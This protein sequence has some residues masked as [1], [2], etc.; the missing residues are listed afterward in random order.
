M[1][2]ISSRET[3]SV[4][5]ASDGLP[6]EVWR[7]P[8]ERS[9]FRVELKKTAPDRSGEPVVTV[10]L[11]QVRPKTRTVSTRRSACASQLWR[12]R[13]WLRPDVPAP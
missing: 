10:R 13:F 7:T 11:V 9:E 8:A 3:L 12:S 2:V 5:P 6:P 4:R 1:S